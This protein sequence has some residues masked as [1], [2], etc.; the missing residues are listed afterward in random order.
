MLQGD[1][2]IFFVH[3]RICGKNVGLLLLRKNMKL[4]FKDVNKRIWFR[5]NV[6]GPHDSKK[7]NNSSSLKTLRVITSYRSVRNTT[8]AFNLSLKY[9]ANM[10]L[11][12]INHHKKGIEVPPRF[13]LG[14]LDS[15][16]R[17]L[18]ITPW[19]LFCKKGCL[20]CRNVKCG[21]QTKKKKKNFFLLK[22]L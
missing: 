13:E 6:F 15:K 19:D 22:F 21:G 18:T 1:L 17:V 4:F 8:E 7:P 12:S 16:S 20:Q 11:T 14:S 10:Y 5:E 9:D 3:V 2:Y